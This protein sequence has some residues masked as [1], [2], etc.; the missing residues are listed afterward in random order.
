MN[1]HPS[2]SLAAG[3]PKSLNLHQKLAVF[4]GF[5]SLFILVLATFGIDFPNKTLW[6]T[7]ALGGIFLGIVWFSYAAYR[8]D[9]AGIKNNGVWF[10]SVSGRGSGPGAWASR[11]RGSTSCSIS[12]RNT[13][14]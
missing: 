11:L 2:M 6:L 8:K 10:K 14:A 9:P 7:T 5:S 4:L 13:W 3:P 1:T 12:S